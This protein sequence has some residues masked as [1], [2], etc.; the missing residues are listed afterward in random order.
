[1]EA[2]SVCDH[3]KQSNTNLDRTTLPDARQLAV[4]L[5]GNQG[6]FPRPMQLKTKEC[7]GTAG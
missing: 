3:S 5:A 4:I 6:G 2:L 1:M 7:A